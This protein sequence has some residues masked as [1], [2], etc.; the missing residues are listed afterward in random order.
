MEIGSFDSN[1]P[2]VTVSN[3]ALSPEARTEQVQ[4][5]KAVKAVNSAELFGQNTELTFVMDRQ[6]KRPVLRLVDV[7]TKEVIRQVPTEYAL[8]LAQ[9][10][11]DKSLA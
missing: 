7:R 2:P 5:I 11:Q 3:T 10:A 1:I 6:S 8:R 9:A 4:L